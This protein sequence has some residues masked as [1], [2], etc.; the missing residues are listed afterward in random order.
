MTIVRAIL[1][2]GMSKR[3][4]AVKLP[5]DFELEWLA[6]QL[7]KHEEGFGDHFSKRDNT[8]NDDSWCTLRVL[9]GGT[10]AEKNTDEIRSNPWGQGDTQ[11]PSPQQG[12]SSFWRQAGLL[13]RLWS[14]S[15]LGDAQTAPERSIRSAKELV[16]IRQRVG[17]LSQWTGPASDNAVALGNAIEVVLNTLLP[18]NVRS[19]GTETEEFTWVLDVQTGCG[20][21]QAA[22]NGGSVGQEAGDGNGGG[23]DAGGGNGGDDTNDQKIVLR[24]V[25]KGGNKK[26]WQADVDQIEALLS[27]WLRHAHCS[28]AAP[29][30]DSDM[31]KKNW[32][33]DKPR[34]Q[35]MLFLGPDTLLLRRDLR[36][37]VPGDG[38]ASLLQVRM[39]SDQAT[40]QDA[41]PNTY[42]IS[43]QRI[44]GFYGPGQPDGQ[45]Y[46]SRSADYTEVSFDCQAVSLDELGSAAQADSSMSDQDSQSPRVGSSLRTGA[47][48]G[49]TT[50]RKSLGMVTTTSQESLFAQHIFT[51]FMA[52]VAQKVDRIGGK[53]E[54]SQA[55]TSNYSPSVWQHFRLQNTVITKMALGLQNAGLTKSLEEAYLCLIPPLSLQYKLPSGAAVDTMLRN[56]QRFESDFN[57]EKS[58]EAYLD[59]IEVAKQFGVASCPFALKAAIAVVEYLKRVANNSNLHF[60]EKPDLKELERQVRESLEKLISDEVRKSLRLLYIRQERWGEYE[61]LLSRRQSGRRD[62][63]QRLLDSAYNADTKDVPIAAYVGFS[64]LHQKICAGEEWDKEEGRR[65][66]DEQD[67]AGWS[68]LHYAICRNKIDCVKY[69]P[70]S[71]DHQPVRTTLICCHL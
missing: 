48:R 19:A 47:G 43:S 69:Y 33:R 52:V 64:K 7:A 11:R 9:T 26:S 63:H 53:T 5:K 27:L 55:T 36:W 42:R 39:P 1:R 70:Q 61:T 17:Q 4:S 59:L 28:E 30:S 3:P 46:D 13:K 51:A 32:L 45:A 6:T 10:P 58:T 15:K 44:T 38:S 57:W 18:P 37:W 65:Y 25:V 16:D 8:R 24:A 62:E 20:G 40:S 60:E 50:A 21:V 23:Q 22:R 2:R 41:E 35:G 49:V 12:H 54:A 67:V 34:K 66:K 14:G 29:K 31:P 71:T 56:L 68:P